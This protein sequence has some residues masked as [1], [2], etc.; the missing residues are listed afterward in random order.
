M[1]R[2][3]HLADHAV[4]GNS[5]LFL[6]IDFEAPELGMLMRDLEPKKGSTAVLGLWK[7]RE[8]V[9]S[10][11]FE[12]DWKAGALWGRQSVDHLHHCGSTLA[13]ALKLLKQ[14]GP[15]EAHT[16]VRMPRYVHGCPAGVCLWAS[17]LIRQPSNPIVLRGMKPWTGHLAYQAM[18]RHAAEILKAEIRHALTHSAQALAFDCRA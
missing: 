4:A 12:S 18:T 7:C 3:S 6:N 16:A 13:T 8:C 1:I 5:N 11:T 2:L 15:K 10:K 17:Q 14:P 9:S